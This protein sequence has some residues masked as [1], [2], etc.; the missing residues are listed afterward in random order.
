[1]PDNSTNSQ[2]CA[3]TRWV[4]ALDVVMTRH[5]NRPLT[6]VLKRAV[7][8][9]DKSPHPCRS[10]RHLDD[11]TRASPLLPPIDQ[12]GYLPFPLQQLTPHSLSRRVRDL[13]S[14]DLGAHREFTPDDETGAEKPAPVPVV[15]RAVYTQQERQQAWTRR[16]ADLEDLAGQ[17]RAHRRRS[18]R[19]R[20]QPLGDGPD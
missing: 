15:K 12:W 13:L 11:T 8:V 17:R 10:T 19:R 3:I 4:R 14:G 18:P 7:P 5:S 1:M 20:T 6:E 16:R 2:P 9:T